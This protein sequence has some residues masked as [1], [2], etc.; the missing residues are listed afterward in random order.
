[1]TKRSV[2]EIGLIV[3][4]LVYLLLVLI[5]TVWSPFWGFVLVTG[6]T[7]ELIDSHRARNKP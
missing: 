1:V 2:R 5:G 4:G 7:Y 6:A 3:A